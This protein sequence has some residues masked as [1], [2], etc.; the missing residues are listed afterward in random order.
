[1]HPIVFVTGNKGKFQEAKRFF[2]A[3]GMKIVNKKLDIEEKRGT[4][5]EIARDAAEQAYR[6]L[7]TPLFVEDSGLFIHALNGFP[8]E[9]SAWAFKKIGNEGILKLMKSEKN[10]QAYFKSAVAYA[11]ERGVKVFTGVCEGKIAADVRGK[12]GFGYDPIFIPKGKGFTFAERE[13]LKS[14]LSHRY[15][16][17]TKLLKFLKNKQKNR[18]NQRHG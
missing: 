15:N 14:V 11:D 12:G 18:K 9:F 17:I 4:L 13:D 3:E 6:K 7:K 16:S 2:S 5:E 8:G 1:M 10:R